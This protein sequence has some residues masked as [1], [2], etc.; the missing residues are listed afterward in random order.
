MNQVDERPWMVIGPER[1][2]AQVRVP[3]GQQVN[4][5]T[6]KDLLSS[7]GVVYGIDAQALCGLSVRA[8]EER[9]VVVASGQLPPVIVDRQV[10]LASSVIPP[11]TVKSGDTIG[12]LTG[13]GPLLGRAIDGQLLWPMLPP[14][15]G[16]G[17]T[18]DD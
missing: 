12:W 8:T 6:L 14:A 1:V 11:S 13:E 10:H 15:C 3:A 2:T 16:H 18:G 17:I 5:S 4:F 9:S 7:L